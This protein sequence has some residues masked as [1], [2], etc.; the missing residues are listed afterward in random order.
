M[1]RN[2]HLIAG[3]A[4]IAGCQRT[5]ETAPPVSG[6]YRADIGRLCDV[7][8]QSGADRIPESERLLAV[9]QWLPAHLET[10]ESHEFL[11]RIQPLAGEAKAGALDA[12]AHRVGLPDCALAAAWRATEPGH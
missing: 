3:L 11:A 2:A 5:T 9:A 4:V 7:V 8:V 6:P 10:Q 12:E 1:K